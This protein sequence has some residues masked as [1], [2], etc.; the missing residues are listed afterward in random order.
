M[1]PL[2]E[3]TIK[4]LMKEGKLKPSDLLG[5]KLKSEVA[6]KLYA[7]NIRVHKRH[8]IPK[9]IKK[10]FHMEEL[11]GSGLWDTLKEIGS[12]IKHTLTKKTP[13]D[14]NAENALTKLNRSIGTVI[15][16]R[17]NFPPKVRAIL[18]KVG[19]LP[20][21][22]IVIDRTPVKQVLVELLNIISLGTF[23][24]KL[25]ETPYDKLFHLRLLITL[26]NGSTVSLEKNEVINMDENPSISK[27]AELRTIQTIPQGL[28]I[29]NLL[30]G[31][32]QKQG[33]KFYRYS[34]YDNNCQDF[35]VALLTASGVGTG[36]DIEFVKQQTQQLFT[37]LS[38][39]FANL[40]TTAGRKFNEITQGAGM[41]K[42]YVIQSIVFNKEKFTTRKAKAW[43]KKHDF[44]GLVPDIEANTIRFRQEDPDKLEAENYSFRTKEISP[45]LNYVI[46]YK[47]TASN[48]S[49]NKMSKKEKAIIRKLN[50]L[51]QEVSGT[52]M[53]GTGIW[54]A[55]TGLGRLIS[56][57]FTRD[58]I[59]PFEA[60]GKT[61]GA[62]LAPAA[63]KAKEYITAKKGG[64]ASDL[65]HKALPAVVGEVVNKATNY[66]PGLSMV[67]DG[68]EKGKELGQKLASAIGDVSG[69]GYGMK[70]K[71]GG[72]GTIP[73]SEIIH[74]DINS[75]NAQDEAHNQTSGDGVR[76]KKGR[77]KVIKVEAELPFEVYSHAKNE[78]LKQLIKARDMK[79]KQE[80]QEDMAKVFAKLSGRGLKKGS[81]EAK[82][83]GRKMREARQSKA[84]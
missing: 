54:D 33:D 39:K 64:L 83:W 6:K 84:K 23:K 66:I 76:R 3:T 71:K 24:K 55:F 20:I 13:V 4:K 28:T 78:P 36:D 41:T 10:Y 14:K 17:D 81:A 16:G 30:E 19:N 15:S 68:R 63:E 60:I 12:T 34:A 35:I 82:E 79:Q 45:G 7:N 29:N 77:K 56:E 37:G 8:Y 44:K 32:K 53:S 48:K 51:H 80:L 65:V 67:V 47:E 43:L 72:K 74:I 73:K 69:V 2:K 58:V 18:E 46:A 31:G 1:E 40:I 21:T 22:K 49:I 26:N 27:D 5:N 38:K 25:S 70:P 62:V 52:Q 11:K 57:G 9:D 61:T 50:K 75:H 42:P 59:K